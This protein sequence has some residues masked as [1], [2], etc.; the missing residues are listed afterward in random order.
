M[1]LLLDVN[2]WVALFDEAHGHTRAGIRDLWR[3]AQLR[4]PEWLT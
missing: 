1:R 2:V 3:D 4:R